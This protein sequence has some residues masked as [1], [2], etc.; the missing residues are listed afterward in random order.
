MD[1]LIFAL[2]WTVA[3]FVFIGI[4]NDCGMSLRIQYFTALFWGVSG[5]I[6]AISFRVIGV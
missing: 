4:A 6:V 5:V 1:G 2:L 3:F